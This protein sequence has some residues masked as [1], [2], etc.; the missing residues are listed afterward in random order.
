[1]AYKNNYRVVLTNDFLGLSKKL[2]APTRHE[3]NIKIE[4]QK[5]IWN[6]KINRE[7]TKKIKKK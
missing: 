6:E 1:M 3:L 7:L 4:N 2:S 5:R